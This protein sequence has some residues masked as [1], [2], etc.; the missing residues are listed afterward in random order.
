MLELIAQIF[1]ISVLVLAIVAFIGKAFIKATI[2][3]SIQH[4]FNVLLEE[5]KIDLDIQR[6]K[7]WELK[8]EACLNA[9]ELV[10][11]VFSHRFQPPA[12]TTMVK[13]DIKTTEIRKCVNELACSVDNLEVL[14]SFKN[15][16]G[17]ANISADD[18]V[19]FR[20]LIRNELD[21]GNAVDNDRT[22]AFFTRI[23]GDNS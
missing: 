18:I 17:L 11:H 9:L 8:R 2:K 6:T 3:S 1:G 10:N 21:F 5:K 7:K 14:S 20:N 4:G 16:V 13:S 12:G 15:L 19:D 23:P 22:N